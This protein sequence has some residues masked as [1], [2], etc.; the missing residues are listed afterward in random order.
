MVSIRNHR[1]F[2]RGRKYAPVKIIR[3]SELHCSGLVRILLAWLSNIFIDKE[4]T[5]WYQYLT[6]SKTFSDAL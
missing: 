1:D 4:A 2:R 5:F 3:W 6:S